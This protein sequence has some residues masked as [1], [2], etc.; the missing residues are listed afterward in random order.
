MERF[1]LPWCEPDDAFAP[2][3]GE[4]GAGLLRPGR[5]AVDAPWAILVARPSARITFAGGRTHLDGMRTDGSPFV[6]LANIAS[7]RLSSSRTLGDDPFPPFQTGLLGFIGYEAATALEPSLRLPRSPAPF[8]DLAM[9]VYDASLA[10][11]LPTRRCFASGHTR[12][13]IDTLLDDI[14]RMPATPQQVRLVDAATSMDRAA[15]EAAVREVQR[16]IL[17]GKFYQANIARRL[18]FTLAERAGAYDLFRRVAAASAAPFC[19]YLADTG[20]QIVSASPERF[21]R[22]R[23]DAHGLGVIADPIKGT[24]DRSADPQADE[25]ARLALGVDPKERAENVMITD[26]L[27]N[28]LS[29]IA[30]DDSVREDFVCRV[31]TYATVHHLVSRISAR[32]APGESAAS[33]LASLFPC[34]SI[35]G[36]PKL[37]VMQAIA[38]IEGVGRGPYCGAIGYIDDCGDAEFSVAIRTA[39]VDVV[40]R[41]LS[42]SVGCG[43][44]LRSEPS[45]EFE[46]TCAKAR[47]LLG[48]AGVTGEGAS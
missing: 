12:A 30:V 13:A 31:V 9:G 33:V 48:V 40:T 34:G 20:G 15:Y 24:R 18:D 22:I 5:L 29:R 17:D 37:A 19:A 4:A 47:W 32:L 26:L 11:H 28:D 25:A 2:F 46:E 41:R 14:G 42:A 43:I 45:R 21:F 39:S 27:R 8:P 7:A 36:A 23:R 16:R 35:T 44:T 1:E 38:E 6:R 3:A 10:F